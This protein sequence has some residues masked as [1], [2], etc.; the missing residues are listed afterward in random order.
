MHVS[1][2]V[3]TYPSVREDEHVL[4]DVLADR[5]VG[6][7]DV[8][9][10]ALGRV[11]AGEDQADDREVAEA[12]AEQ[13]F[14]VE[15]RAEDDRRLRAHLE[16]AAGGI[17]GTMFV[18]FMPTLACNLACTYCFQ[19]G[20]PAYNTMTRETEDLAVEMILRKVDAA[21]TPRLLVEYFGGEPLARK[22][23]V[24]RTAEILSRSMA[25]RGGTFEWHVISNGINLDL[26]F[27]EAMLRFGEGGVKV[28]LDGDRET[29]DQTRVY[30]SGKGSFDVIFANLA[31]VAGHVSLQ[32]G[33]NFLPGQEESYARLLQR[34]DEAGILGKLDGVRFKPAQ[35]TADNELASCGGSCGTAES[36]TATLITLDRLLRKKK[37]AALRN[38]THDAVG[39]GPCELHWDHSYVID[40]DGLV[41]K[42]PAVAGRP[43]VAIG[44]VRGGAFK[45][46]PLL[47]LRPWEQCGDCAYLPVCVGGCLG[48]QYLKTG[49]RDE[50]NCKK[51]WFAA[52]YRESV[53]RRY[54]AE[55]AD[56][57]WDG[58]GD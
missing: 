45:E 34:L 21:A 54:L 19:K 7:N 37:P 36:E 13:G 58:A 33:G 35:P 12:L 55:L 1:R 24:L 50:V 18:T 15:G 46:A 31:A 53:P 14:V 39:S 6:V 47:E 30:R 57:P 51:E 10:A 43:E 2:F 22:D 29:H 52:G 42:C 28:T 41:Y 49:R 4:Y 44:D 16:R 9:L 38:D 5:Y 26:P 11:A 20:S 32:V 25:A 17:P 27:V 56:V 23:V 8:A 48:G 40:P 3:V